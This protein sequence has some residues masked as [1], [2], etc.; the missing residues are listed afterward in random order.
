MKKAILTLISL[1]PLT[2]ISVAASMKINDMTREEKIHLIQEAMEAQ[3][4]I[5]LNQI[6]NDEDLD[7]AIEVLL[8]NGNILDGAKTKK[9]S[10]GESVGGVGGL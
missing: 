5:I 3:P 2:S 7:R 6:E 4:E 8:K 1:L 9:G 10:G